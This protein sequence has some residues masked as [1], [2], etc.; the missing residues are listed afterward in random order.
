MCGV[1][2][3]RLTDGQEHERNLPWLAARRHSSLERALHQHR[4]VHL[5][6]CARTYWLTQH[7][8]LHAISA[9]WLHGMSASSSRGDDWKDLFRTLVDRFIRGSG[10]S[11]PC[12]LTRMGLGQLQGVDKDLYARFIK[13]YPYSL[14]AEPRNPSGGGRAPCK[15]KVLQNFNRHTFEQHCKTIGCTAQHHNSDDDDDDD[16]G[17]GELHRELYKLLSQDDSVPSKPVRKRHEQ[18][19]GDQQILWPPM[20]LLLKVG[21]DH[22]SAGQLNEKYGGW[23]AQG[24]AVYDHRGFAHRAVL[25]FASYA[26]DHM[27]AFDK[28]YEKLH[29]LRSRP[30][31]V[32]EVRWVEPRDGRE[33]EKQIWAK[34]LLKARV[35]ERNLSEMQRGRDTKRRKLQE[36]RDEKLRTAEAEKRE[37]EAKAARESAAA[38]DAKEAEVRAREREQRTLRDAH[39]NRQLYERELNRLEEENKALAEENKAQAERHDAKLKE[40]LGDMSGHLEKSIYEAE[41]A[42]QQKVELQRRFARDHAESPRPSARHAYMCAF[43]AQVRRHRA[44]KAAEVR[45]RSHAEIGIEL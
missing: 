22:D 8:F 13:A 19:G 37:A 18:V 9:T 15:G 24:H 39:E 17:K 28:A 35:G 34:K 31:E 14:P 29:D 4:K 5:E 45:P 16:G 10:P 25:L 38:R 12:P 2:Q 32:G 26:D 36:E 1:Q 7:D 43:N 44:G 27:D 33:W 3:P 20:L 23:G 21:N 42:K 30:S 6:S 40:A 41:V 11:F